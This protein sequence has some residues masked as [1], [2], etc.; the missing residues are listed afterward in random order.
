MEKAVQF[1]K[2]GYSRRVGLEIQPKLEV[3]QRSFTLRRVEDS[4]DYATHRKYIRENPVRAKLVVS[5]EEYLYSSANAT[6]VVD[7]PPGH[8][9]G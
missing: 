9:M 3:W 4:R 2:G 8:L 5:A 7:P 1:I 6:F